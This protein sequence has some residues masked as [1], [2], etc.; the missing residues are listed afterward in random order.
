MA[1]PRTTLLQISLLAIFPLASMTFPASAGAQAP[2]ASPQQLVAAMVQRENQ[3]HLDHYEYTAQ[4]RSDRT[5]GHMWT[6]RVVELPAGRVRLLVAEDGKPL[7]ADRLQ[8]E[9]ERLN[10]IAASPAAWERVEN[11]EKNDEER[12]R[13]MLSLLP[14]AFLLENP[15]LEDGTWHLDFRPNPEYSPSGVEERVL[16][17]MSGTLAIDAKDLRLVHIEGHLPQDV[18]IGFGL[19][20]TIHSGSRFESTR[21]KIE[22]HWRT[23]H[24]LTDIRG[25]AALFKTVAKN[26]DVTRSDFHYLAGD[27]TPVEAVALVEKASS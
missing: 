10:A 25:K 7:S 15:R 3:A 27:V 1:L 24:V 21:E 2:P 5:G 17:G 23:V 26:T 19:L 4:E 22:G 14:K 16:H 13:Q 12:A 8:V 20:A 6:E 11:A 18:A 9:R